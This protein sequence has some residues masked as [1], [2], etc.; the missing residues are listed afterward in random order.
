M[1]QSLWLTQNVFSG[2][3]A[4]DLF[5]AGSGTQYAA[6]VDAAT[7]DWSVEVRIPWTALQ[8]N[9]ISEL[10]PPAIGDRAGF[11]LL[12]IDYGSSV[13]EWMGCIENAPW[14]GQE[15]QTMTFVQQ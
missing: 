14:T 4:K 6:A 2:C 13:L 9:F 3:L 5:A 7:G 1:K 8:G 15:L 11:S 10:F 12:G